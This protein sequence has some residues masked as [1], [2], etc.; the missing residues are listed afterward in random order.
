MTV[1][2]TTGAPDEK[3]LTGKRGAARSTSAGYLGGCTPV[4][5]PSRPTALS[6]R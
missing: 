5:A 1:E 2:D 6:M 4:A 3:W